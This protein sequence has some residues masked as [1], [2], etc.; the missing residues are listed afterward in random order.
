MKVG[1]LGS[2]IVGQTLGSGF[3]KYGHQ[4][5]IGTSNPNKLNDWIKSSGTNA[6]VG[7]FAD[8]ASFGEIISSC[9]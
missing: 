6:S 7:S 4:V 8:A 2:G 3:I 9:C 5:K 1:I